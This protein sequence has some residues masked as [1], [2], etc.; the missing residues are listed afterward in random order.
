MGRML[1]TKKDFI[2]RIMSR[3]PGLSDPARPALV[4]LKPTDRTRTLRAGSHLLPRGEAPVAANDH[5][6]VTSAAFSPTLGHAIALALLRNGRERH[7][8]II[9]VH[10]PLRGGDLQAEVCNPIF[11]DAEGVRV[12]G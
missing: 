9:T 12:R 8:E 10:D 6:Y 1:S 7:G 3:R 11:V 2:G 5:G 4:G